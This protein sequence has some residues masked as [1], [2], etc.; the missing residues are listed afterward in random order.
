MKLIIYFSPVYKFVHSV[1][2]AQIIWQLKSEKAQFLLAEYLLVARA[3]MAT[4][5]VAHRT[6]AGFR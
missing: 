2:L 5:N 1:R 6:W 4:F 3:R